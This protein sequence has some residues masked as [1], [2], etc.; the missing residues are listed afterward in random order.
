MY[1]WKKFN[2]SK[3][4]ENCRKV[5]GMLYVKFEIKQKIDKFTKKLFSPNGRK[6]EILQD[7]KKRWSE[8]INTIFVSYWHKNGMEVYC[9]K[10]SDIRKMAAE[11]VETIKPFTGWGKKV[12][13]VGRD[14]LLY[15][16]KRYPPTTSENIAKAIKM[17]INEIFPLKDPASYFRIFEQTATYCLVDIWAWDCSGYKEIRSSFPFTH[18]LP[19][20]V[21]FASDEPEMTLFENNGLQHLIAHDKNGFLGSLSFKDITEKGFE[22]FLRSLG[23]Y[24]SG[25]RRIRL[26]T[27]ESKL[28]LHET[29][30]FIHEG[31]KEYHPCLKDIKK[32]NLK[33]FVFA[34][35]LPFNLN[36][37][38]IGRVIIYILI[39]YSLSLLVT[40]RNYKS[41]YKETLSRLNALTKELS[42]V[43]PSWSSEDYSDVINEIQEKLKS[44]VEPLAIMDILAKYIPEKGYITKMDFNEKNLKL[45]LSSVDPLNIIKIL[46]SAECVK[47]V[48]LEGAPPKYKEDNPYS[49]ILSLEL[50]PCNDK[51]QYL[52]ERGYNEVP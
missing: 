4:L 25:I 33:E 43:K 5:A 28:N 35:E 50:N 15:T 46:S 37:E 29:M 26:Y 6:R 11:K 14:R 8:Q 3:Q 34:R 24:S 10:D 45:T 19:E 7:L 16:R 27:S 2:L 51:I 20:D 48:R 1:I 49:F 39:I 21:A 22:S 17:D 30:P 32:L 23:K 40:G 44:R 18:I 52:N 36:L 42:V 31:Q 38:L 41:T 9:L 47:S 12:M 13:I